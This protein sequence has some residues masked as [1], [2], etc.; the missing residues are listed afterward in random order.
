MIRLK[1]VIQEEHKLLAIN[2][3]D[4]NLNKKIS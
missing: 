4:I 3:E 1:Q 2:T